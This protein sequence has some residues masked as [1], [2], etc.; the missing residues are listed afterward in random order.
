MFLGNTLNSAASG[1]DSIERQ[2]A[3]LSQ[4][5]ANANTPNYVRQTLPLSSLDTAG[6]PAGVRV[7]LAT[8]SMD[9]HLQG[10]VFTAIGTE[11]GSVTTKSALAGIDQIAGK[12]GN[13]QDL[14]SLLGAVRDSF[15]TLAND[16]ASGSQQLDVLDKAGALTNGLHTIGTG[17]VQARQTAQDTLVKDVVT[18]NDSLHAVGVLSDQIIATK[19][20]GQSTADLENQRDGEKRTLAEL[21]GARFLTQPNGD[22]L[23]LAGNSPLSTRAKTGPLSIGNANFSGG[24]P[25]ASV[26]PLKLDDFAV[27]GLGGKI[28]ANLALR[29]T[30]VPALQSTL[31]QFAQ[32][33]ASTFQGQGLPLFTDPSG[34]VPTTATAGFAV[35]IQVSAAAQANP[36]IVRDGTGTQGAAGDSTVINNV[37]NNVFTSNSTGLSAQAS[38]LVAAYA[39][40]ASRAQAQ[41]TTNTAVRSGLETRLAAVTGVS[42]DSEL[43][44]MV[45]LQAAYAAN[46]KV[47]TAVQAMWNQLLQVVP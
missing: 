16:P 39:Q 9:E 23:V 22:L 46:A 34:A 27:A 30:T 32:S 17:L 42:V 11:S 3:L 5:V 38:S 26:P 15:S 19:A 1:L 47:L 2:I 25:A 41:V 18:V 12:P 40:Q 43:A 24:T 4:N 10:Q 36:A 13:G 33:L 14:S 44:H 31:D 6:G 45:Q 7:G 21:T 35:T 28:G 20:S 8:R 37:L 29:D